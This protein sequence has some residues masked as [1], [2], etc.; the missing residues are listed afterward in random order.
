[1]VLDAGFRHSLYK[2]SGGNPLFTV[3]FLKDLQERGELLKDEDGFWVVGRQREWSQLPVRVE[4][5]IA[6]RFERLPR[7]CRATLMAGSV[8][9]QEFVA[10]V[11]AGV[12]GADQQETIRCLSELLC[13]QHQLV[14][15]RHFRQAGGRPVSHNRFR[16]G[17]L[18]L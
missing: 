17:G 4:A 13:F 16:C 15:A 2:Q 5:V 9:G 6:E 18:S 14:Q 3:E 8:Q 7:R 1:M 11:V 10:E 12:K